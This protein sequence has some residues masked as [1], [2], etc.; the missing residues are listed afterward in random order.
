MLV[1]QQPS[2]ATELSL[3]GRPLVLEVYLGNLQITDRATAGD[4]GGVRIL[5]EGSRG[6]ILSALLETVPAPLTSTQ[7]RDQRWPK[8]SSVPMRYE[9]LRFSEREGMALVEY[10]VPE[11]QGK[12][13]RQRSVFAFLAAQGLCAVVHVSKINYETSDN[14]YM[15]GL[16]DA[17]RLEPPS[18][19][20]VSVDSGTHATSV[21]RRY[22]NQIT[23][24][25]G[26]GS[27]KSRAQGPSVAN[28]A[29]TGVAAPAQSGPTPKP[30][31]PSAQGRRI[32]FVAIGD[33]PD[34]QI[35]QLVQYYRERFKL[36]IQTLAAIPIDPSAIDPRRQQLVAERLIT[37]VRNAFPRLANDANAILIGFTL[38]DMYPASMNWRFAFG[39]RIANART[40][41]VSTAR[42]DLH[43]PGEPSDVAL[44]EIRLRKVV[45]KDIGI[46]YYGLPQSNNP[47]SVL[48]GKIL[49]IEELDRVSEE[50]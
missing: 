13:V 37:S 30:N 44:P 3:P 22:P 28:P 27:D 5:A 2:A 26:Q 18:Q 15:T 10:E 6:F 43:Y 34:D 9:H 8:M 24:D 25:F 31:L 47:R 12:P 16:I 45:T 11:F 41:V 1:A 7:C 23:I 21:G 14:E 46:L 39:W 49:G 17:A 38:T 36:G 42:M 33:F 50:F 35:Q 29:G 4:G 48:Y 20:A 19:A 32:Y 40:A